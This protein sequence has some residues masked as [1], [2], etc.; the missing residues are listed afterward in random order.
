MKASILQQRSSS[1]A[2]GSL[3]V[4]RN[5]IPRRL[6]ATTTTI[7]AFQ[8]QRPT[9]FDVPISNN[10]ARVR[11][12]LYKKGLEKEVDVIPPQDIGG[13]KSADYMALNPQGKMPLLIL[14][15][16]TSIPE[17]QVIESYILDKYKG[18][19]PDLLPPTPELRALATLAARIHDLYMAPIQ[20]CMYKPMPSPGQRAVQLYQIN[21]Q[22]NVLEE[23][24]VGPFFCG[25]EISFADSAL[26]PTFVFYTW[27]LP[28]YFGWG[29]V[30]TERPKLNAWWGAVSRDP[31]AAR[32]IE[33][34]VGGLEGWEANDRWQKT[35]VNEHVQDGNYD[36][37]LDN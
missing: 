10:G 4:S 3:S 32:V 27:I 17:S 26:F 19:G 21:F 24:V 20:G 13:L 25:K 34:M 28:R 22:L 29:S 6:R 1:I 8:A 16:G 9:L 23:M 30:F 31:E 36:W 18:T 35:G 12:L 14:P 33:E 7:S 2:P 5:A 11:F 37:T 15:D